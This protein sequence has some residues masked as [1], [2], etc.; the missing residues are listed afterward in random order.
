MA[1][2]AS[3]Q[4][5]VLFGGSISG[6]SSDEVW[7]WNGIQ[8]DLIATGGPDRREEHVLVYDSDRKRVVLFGGFRSGI[9]QPPFNDV[10]EWN[11]AT[12]EEVTPGGAPPSGRR[13]SA[14]A[15]DQLQRALFVFSGRFDSGTTAT[16]DL[17]TLA[18]GDW[19]LRNPQIRRGNR[20]SFDA[21]RNKLVLFGGWDGQTGYGDTWEWDGAW[22][23]RSTT[24]PEP[25]RY[26]GLAYDPIRQ[27]TVLFGGWDG[28]TVYGDTWEWD[29][30]EWT[31]RSTT[32][33]SPR[34]YH[35]MV[36]DGTGVLLYGGEPFAEDT[37]RWDGNQ[38]TMLSSSG[39]PQRRDHSMA[40]DSARGVAV[41]H[42]GYN[43]SA[44]LSDT[45]EWDG[46]AW[47][48]RGAGSRARWH[49]SAFDASRG[50]V[51]DYGRIENPQ[52]QTWDGASWTELE[53]V[54]PGRREQHDLAYNPAKGVTYLFG[55]QG[56]NSTTF[57]EL[58]ELGLDLRVRQQPRS[59]V[60]PV[61]GTAR[62]TAFA[63]AQRLP[64]DYQW[65]FN[66]APLANGGPV[67]GA[68]SQTLVIDPVSAAHVGEYDAVVT[69]RCGE[70]ITEP[71][72]LNVACYAD[73][74]GNTVLDIFDF[75]CFQDL[76][77]TGNPE[78]DCDGN[79]VL[80]VFDFLC[81]QDAF[82]AGCP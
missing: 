41:V 67:S 40:Y 44:V 70:L 69:S 1:Y 58:W 13:E 73:C 76:F 26:H 65:R 32:G 66:G 47:A 4:R 28:Q 62:F 53:A 12:W 21:A 7:E 63:D 80:D 78:A 27:R 64:I 6:G 49:A 82:V 22:D 48:S 71:A 50:F 17:W 9:A 75:L 38:W 8:W 34:R 10:W 60:V 55:G 51:V 15:Y 45:W 56:M 23:R 14:V 59:V 33:P 52:A 5:V 54:E 20:L 2:D 25:R 42:G 57:N 72:S 43:G 81:F 24:G 36:F 68:Q 37:W 29:G 31:L 11:G 79:T 74:D 77:A 61:G 35:R 18:G 3:R 16:P 19:E 39:P 46:M 30:D